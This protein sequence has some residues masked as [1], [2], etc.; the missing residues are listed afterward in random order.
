M[1]GI[2]ISNCPPSFVTCL[3]VPWELPVSQCQCVVNIHAGHSVHVYSLPAKYI[4]SKID[5]YSCEKWTTAFERL[6]L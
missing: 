5:K 2:C 4:F 3:I 6:N 1:F